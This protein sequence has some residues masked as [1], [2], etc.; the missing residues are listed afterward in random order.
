MTT[1]KSMKKAVEKRLDEGK[2]IEQIGQELC[3]G[4]IHPERKIIR[5]IKDIEGKGEDYLISEGKNI[6]FTGVTQLKNA[7]KQREMKQANQTPTPAE[8]KVQ[9]LG[10]KES[11]VVV[12]LSV[13]DKNACL[14]L[15]GRFHI[16]YPNDWKNFLKDCIKEFSDSI[17]KPPT[18]PEI[19]EFSS[20][21]SKPSEETGNVIADAIADI[22]EKE[23]MVAVEPI[24]TNTETK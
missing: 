21:Y 15:I 24:G 8:M 23:E 12:K 4:V 10:L 17:S 13:E 19:K 6:G 1:C 14:E 16:A 22:K 20:D 5:I 9:N 2:T 11:D 7:M 18:N 3:G